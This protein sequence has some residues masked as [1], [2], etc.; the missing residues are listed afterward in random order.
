[1]LKEWDLKEFVLYCNFDTVN[2]FTLCQL[3]RKEGKKIQQH[4]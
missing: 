4:S 1:M 2:I 3:F